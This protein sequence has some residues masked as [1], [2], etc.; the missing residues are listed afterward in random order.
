MDNICAVID[1]QGFNLSIGFIPKELAISSP[2]LSQCQELNPDINWNDLNEEDVKTINYTTKNLNGLHLLPF[3][4]KAYAFL[5][6]SENVDLVIKNWYSEI[7]SKMPE[8]KYLFAFKNCYVKNIL[9]RCEIPSL[10]L[11][12]IDFPNLRE[13][14]RKYGYHYL[15][16][17][18]KKP[19]RGI[20][21][22]CAYR[23]SNIIFREIIERLNKKV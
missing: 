22:T 8:D 1:I 20:K 19:P 21:L 11:D 4:D 13:L 12:D 16:A 2:F 17:Y 9:E 18:H 6:K 5:P 3:N 15:C 10:N 7:I 14:N 23:K